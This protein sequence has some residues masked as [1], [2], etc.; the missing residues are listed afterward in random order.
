MR[1]KFDPGDKVHHVDGGR[2][3]R[4]EIVVRALDGSCFYEC[5]WIEGEYPRMR[6]FAEVNLKAAQQRSG[7]VTRESNIGFN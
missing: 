4:V 7:G 5:S 1:N 2:P 6:K 3:L